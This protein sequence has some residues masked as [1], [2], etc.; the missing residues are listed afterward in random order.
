VAQTVKSLSAVWETQVLSLGWEDSPGE[1]NGNPFQYP[2]LEN[3]MDEGV[4][5]S[6]VHGV[7][8]SLT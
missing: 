7:E 1:G 6:T 5:Q 2:C 8:K 3:Y 4:W